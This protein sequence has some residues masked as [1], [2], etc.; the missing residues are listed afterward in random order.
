M[1]RFV[2]IFVA[3]VA[4]VIYA[5]FCHAQLTASNAFRTVPKSVL[6]HFDETMKLDL[7]D[8]AKAAMTNKV[9]NRHGSESCI[10]KMTDNYLDLEVSPSSDVQF[11]ILPIRGKKIIALISTVMTPAPDSSLRFYAGNWVPIDLDLFRAPTLDDWLTSDGKKQSDR[12]VE[13]VPFLMTGYH[14][15]EADMSLTISLNL[16]QYLTVEAYEEVKTL[17]HPQLTYVWDGKRFNLKK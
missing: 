15:E 9:K 13:L 8:Y 2:T 16:N 11:A 5:P 4:I 3:F 17:L 7:I 10:K 6:D 1:K 12:V 14:Y